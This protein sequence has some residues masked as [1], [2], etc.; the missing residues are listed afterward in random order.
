MKKYFIVAAALGLAACSGK[1]REYD[2]SGVFEATE[3]MVSA[4]TA[5]ELVRFDL[6]EG[7]TVKAG[8]AVGLIDTTQLHLR[9]LGLEGSLKAVDARRFN[10]E[11]QL[12]SLRQQITTARTEQARFEN[13]VRDNAATQ[14]QLDDITAHLATLEKQLAAQTE[15]LTSGNRSL[16][17]ETQAMWAQLAQAEDQIAKSV[18][19]SPIEGTVL[20]KYAEQGE[21]AG[22]GRA[23]F[24]VA[25][26]TNIFLRVYITAD[27]LTVLQ[28]GQQVRVFADWGAD[29]RREYEGTVS[30]ISDRAEFTPKTIQTRDERANLVYAVKVAVTNDGYIKSGMYGE[31]KLKVEGEELWKR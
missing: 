27:Q 24:K 12:A 16:D 18:V 29:E 19:V 7:R 10:V 4:R 20:A 6:R 2:A 8:E 17:G 23:L 31:V 5:G 13:L 28:L 9:K 22:Q 1:N 11:R 30:W 21:L 14:K 26:M 15:T 25:D 3:V